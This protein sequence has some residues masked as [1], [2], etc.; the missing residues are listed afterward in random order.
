M[1]NVRLSE[2]MPLARQGKNNVSIMS[3]INPAIPKVPD[4]KPVPMLIRVKTADDADE[5]FEK[6]K[7]VRS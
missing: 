7:E 3:I 1:L 5:L 2:S 4:D 6:M